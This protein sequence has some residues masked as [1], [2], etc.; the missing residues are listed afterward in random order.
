MTIQI[1]L[2]TSRPGMMPLR[3]SAQRLAL[4]AFGLA[5]STVS[6]LASAVCAA[7]VNVYSYREPQLIEPL[8]KAFTAKSGITVNL[9]FARDGLNER[10]A[11]EGRNSP[12]DV[13]LTADISRLTAAKVDLLTQS[14]VTPA[15][16]GA[17]PA[18]HRDAEGHWI[19]LTMRARVLFASRERVKEDA[20]DYTSLA[21]P[22]WRGRI[23][24]RSGQHPYNTA[25]IA[26]MI[27]HKGEAETE[28]WLRGVKQNLAQ[29][30][31]GGD[32][33]QVRDVFSGK[34]DLALGNTYYMGLMMSETQRPEQKQWAASVKTIFPRFDGAG[35]HVNVSGAAIARHAPHRAE[36]Q[37]L[38][39]YLVSDAAQELYAGANH[40]YPV[41]TKVAPSKIVESFGKLS[42]DQLPLDN[43][44]KWRQKASELVDKVNF[45]AGPN[46]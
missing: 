20:I 10:L 34:C 16:A 44:S 32:R 36:A 25:L 21:D 42:A 33:E 29:R 15:M 5:A 45:D 17:I 7:E 2:S 26:A 9:V 39:E 27:A 24:S 13:L 18:A 19:A 41:N 23:C 38:L 40:E 37:A 1:Q 8:L 30:P 3:R 31:A 46:S 14:F 6:D 35:T 22:K 4:I 43:I 28:R 12:A 11:A